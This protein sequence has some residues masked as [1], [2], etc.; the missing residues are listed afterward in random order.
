MSRQ[1]TSLFTV[2]IIVV[3]LVTVIF[4]ALLASFARQEIRDECA[5]YQGTIAETKQGP[6]CLLPSRSPL[7][8][9]YPTWMPTPGLSEWGSTS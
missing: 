1:R 9:G 6:L 8:T 2:I 3:V 4:A 7:P 5:R